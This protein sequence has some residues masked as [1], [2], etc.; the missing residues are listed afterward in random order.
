MTFDLGW[1]GS[2]FGARKSCEAVGYP[3]GGFSN[4]VPLGGAEWH[5]RDENKSSVVAIFRDMMRDY[6]DISYEERNKVWN[7]FL[8]ATKYSLAPVQAAAAKRRRRRPPRAPS[9]HPSSAGQSKTE[10]RDTRAIKRATRL[11]LE[12]AI[13]KATKVLDKEI[14]E[15]TL[16][17]DVIFEKL[18]QLH[19]QKPITFNLPSDAP[20][21][22]CINPTELRSAGRRLAKG[23]SPGP[24]GITDVIIRILLDDEICCVSFC[25]ML[26]DL[27]NGE[28][29]KQVM[30]RLRRARLVA[31]P[32]S[33]EHVRPIAVGELILKLAGLILLQR[34]EG[35]LEKLFTP[36]QHGVMLKGGCE[37]VVHKLHA[38]YKEEYAILSIDLKNA[39]NSPSR[40]DIARSVFA[41]HTLKPFH[42]FFHA[43]YAEP[44]E[45]LF[46]GSDD[47]QLFGTVSSTAGVRQ[48]SSLSTLYFCSFLQPLL[49][50]LAQE[51]PELRI[52]AYIDDVNFASKGRS[53][54]FGCVPSS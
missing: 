11:V 34:H 7:R 44:S 12:G 1:C 2:R 42:K 30:A 52:Y 17:D 10:A 48:G 22:A 19:P 23:A 20:Q 25:H 9:T 49:E 8:S 16:T 53:A 21:I 29:S 27:I 35:S 13:S 45:M 41:F 39:F 51:F 46:Y 31:I 47:D 3:N 5:R 18:K 37:Q 50:T 6:K 40:D 43:E 54:P 26:M 38:L 32:K 28:L 15:K 4:L 33:D 36:I 24:T 14:K